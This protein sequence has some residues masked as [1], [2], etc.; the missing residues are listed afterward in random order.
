M[1]EIEVTTSDHKRLDELEVVIEEGLETFIEVGTALKEIQ[2]AGL[3]LVT[4]YDTFKAYC[5]DR[6]GFDR[7]TGYQYINTSKAYWR[8]EEQASANADTDLPLPQV[9][10]HVRP[11]IS[12]DEETQYAAWK[13]AVKKSQDSKSRITMSLVQEA[14]EEIEAE[15]KADK[16]SKDF[17]ELD[18]PGIIGPSIQV[19][20]EEV[21]KSDF[22]IGLPKHAI[23]ERL[24]NKAVP[25][26]SRLADYER[27]LP[28]SIFGEKPPLDEIMDAYRE[29][30][31]TFTFGATNEH[32]DWAAWTWNPVMGCLHTCPYCYARHTAETLKRYA[33][34][35]RPTFAPL[36]LL[37]P[38]MSP[39]PK[40]NGHVRNWNVFTCSMADLFGKWVPDWAIDAV[41]NRVRAHPEWNF[42]FL[43]KFPQKLARF[44]FP[45]N[46]WIGATVD[47]QSRVDL[48]VKHFAAV[49]ARVKWLSCE[50]MLEELTFDSLEMF[51]GIVI[52][53]MKGY[54]S[55]EDFQPE[56]AWIFNLIQQAR[57]DGCT[58]YWKDNLDVPK[59]LPD[60]SLGF[61]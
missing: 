6:W 55:D 11:L 37:A 38:E 21:A 29:L 31:R 19:T 10:A 5:E 18:D 59:Q 35:F 33:Q 58:I 30:G 2:E 3:F 51:D 39:A 12:K 27:A 46:A 61:A 43:T 22:L 50:P 20:S 57:A 1:P 7:K 13:R 9:Q 4:G 48:T 25:I 53:A 32:V 45:D 28:A 17:D 23:P 47:E 14:V 16:D 40:T 36:R 24:M 42:L 34:G 60:G 56:P 26:G 8:I 52:G 54:G 15:Q 44:D 41:L 49:D